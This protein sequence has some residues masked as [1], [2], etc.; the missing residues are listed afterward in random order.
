MYILQGAIQG[1]RKR[2]RHGNEAAAALDAVV[3]PKQE[4]SFCDFEYAHG[5][6]ERNERI[7]SRK[8][9]NSKMSKNDRI[10]IFFGKSSEILTDIISN[11]DVHSI[12]VAL[13]FVAGSMA[14][15]PCVCRLAWDRRALE[16]PFHSQDD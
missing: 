2:Y 5:E 15:V 16:A 4:W 6:N 3:H 9:Q 13:S 1:E 14:I 12:F 10:F 11:D 8:D 7:S